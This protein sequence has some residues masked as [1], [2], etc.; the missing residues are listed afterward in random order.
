M[1]YCL[2]ASGS[3]GNATWIQEGDQALLIDNG[4]SASNLLARA[5]SRGLI[6][7]Q[8]R[9]IVVS[10]EHSDHVKGIGP[11]A[12]RERLTVWATQATIEASGP[13]LSGTRLQR[14]QAGEELDLGF[15]TIATIPTSHDAADPLAFVVKNRDAQLGVITDLGVATHLVR[16]SLKNLSALVVEFNHDVGKLLDGP[17]PYFLKQRVRSRLGHL[18]NE[19]GAELLSQIYHPG[20]ARVILGHLSETNNT[21]ELALAAAQSVLD[22][23]GARP[24]LLVGDQH[25]P[26][27]V[28]E[29]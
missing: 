2:L 29:L 21:P 17:Y 15:L 3:R 24:D 14:F 11:L 22:R 8:L 27:A 7:S 28:F 20:L 9:A 23:L 25:T 16:D 26:T 1:K 5:R 4:L 13:A 12:R 18:S 10:H 6:A 19:E